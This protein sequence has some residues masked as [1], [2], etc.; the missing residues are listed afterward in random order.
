MR[1]IFLFVT[2]LSALL[3]NAQSGDFPFGK[4]TYKELEMKSYVAD[5]STDA[6][7]LNEF[8]KAW[9]SD[10]QTLM[11]EYHTKI[12]ILKSSGHRQ[13][14]FIVPLYKDGDKEGKWHSLEAVTFNIVN[15]S[16]K[17]SKFD[18]KNLFTE[19]TN[20]NVSL[21][22]FALP[23]VSVGSIIEVKYLTESPFLYNFHTWEFQDEIPKLHS[24]YW[25]NIPANWIYNITLRGFHQLSRSESDVEKNC[26]HPTGIADIAP[27]LKLKYAMENIPAFK[28]ERYMTTPKNFISAIYFEMA[29]FQ[30]FDGSRIRYAEEW[31][32][33]ESKLLQHEKFGAQIKKARNL[34]EDIIKP[35]I[36]LE[37]DQLK[38][39]NIIFDY[40]KHY[41]TWNGDFG[42]F[43]DK[44]VKNA[45]EQKRGNTADINLCL[46]GALQS[47]KLDVVPIVLSTRE[48]GIPIKVQPQLTG[49]NYVVA[50][51]KVNDQ[52][53]LLDATDDFLPFG[54]LPIRCLNDQGRIVSKD[55]STW[56]DLKP[57][58]KQKKT[59]GMDLQLNEDGVL[60]GSL[61]VQ[62][63]GY[64]GIAERRK[65]VKTGQED[66]VAQLK[67]EF[68]QL[69]ISDFELQNKEDVTKPLVQKM[70]ISSSGFGNSN[71][72]TF[73]FNPFMIERFESNP[74]KSDERFY[75]VDLGAPV[76]SNYFISVEMPDNWVVDES[77]ANSAFSLP[78]GGGKCIV[79]T[80]IAGKKVTL[81]CMIVLAKPIY[82]SEEY[83]FLREFFSRVVQMH[84]S[85]FVFKKI[86]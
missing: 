80:A 61:T 34:L 79:N 32:N 48:N 38:K 63:V 74:F 56:V 47:A 53:Y 71:V 11:F 18:A 66:Y 1:I 58:Q 4:I 23:D 81:N 86:K 76:E 65:F 16:L 35:S 85:Q 31:K 68:D 22:K 5:T 13:G 69:E 60:K 9:I 2:A 73:Y 7:V 67:K 84:Q 64:D 55:E 8:G 10:N 75:P 15:S 17:E 12:K 49:F 21:V 3:A 51:L 82:T 62:Y 44:G 14:D 83:H 24:E 70:Q 43:T 30:R 77:P 50:F 20:R 33:V 41:F 27:C 57:T 19:K 59:I 52:K 29:E 25:C 42:L 6:L 78:N 37:T 46:I 45:Y 54:V 39:A 26:F 72:N 36:E 40:I 28:K